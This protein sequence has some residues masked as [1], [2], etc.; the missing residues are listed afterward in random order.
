MNNS[1][2][3][4]ILAAI[5]LLICTFSS[6]SAQ[7]VLPTTSGVSLFCQGVDLVLDL[8][9]QNTI[10][11]MKYSADKSIPPTE[12]VALTNGTTIPGASLKTGYYYLSSKSTV[13]GSC[14]SE[15]QEIPVYVLKP[16]VVN[17]TPADFCLESPLAQIGNVSSP[18]ANTQA[19]AYQ[20]YT[21]DGTV[22]T[23]IPGQTTKD[24][25]PSAPA[26]VGIKT[27][28]LK[29]G[30]VINGNKYCPQ[31][32]DHDV[33]VTAKPVKPTITPGIITGTASAV[34]F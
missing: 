17:F 33:K 26:T 23:A 7:V 15:L 21:V 6:V 34:T 20:W 31:W 16:L 27:H 19:F 29:V 18:D 5:F 9:A 32:A 2:T 10:W 11:I 28:R 14:E 22:E 12:G 4:T 8:P 13:D 30:Y 25:T 24:Y 1:I 3:K